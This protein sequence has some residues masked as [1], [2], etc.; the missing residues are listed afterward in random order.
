PPAAAGGTEPTPA[1]APAAEPNPFEQQIAEL[2]AQLAALQ[3]TRSA[4]ASA[5]EAPPA[6]AA[7]PVYT[8]EEQS[9][10]EKYWQDWPDIAAGEQLQRKSEYVA[11]V[12]HIFNQITP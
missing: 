3:E 9:A 4:P 11:I 2:R 8:A 10:L 12:N 5:A 7:K 6:P 1:P